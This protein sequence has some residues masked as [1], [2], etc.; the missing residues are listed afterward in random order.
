MTDFFKGM[1]YVFSGVRYVF[2]NGLKRFIFIPIAFNL[3]LFLT[4]LYL[5]YHYV[6][7]FSDYYISKLPSWLGFLNDL[8]L[9][10]FFIVFFLLFICTFTV[11]FNVL[12][13]PFNGLL[14]EKAQLLF[15]RSAIPSISFTEMIVR[16]IKR[17]GQ[18]LA[19]FI[20]R[21]LGL[22]I[23]FF[24]PL[25][26]PIYPFLWILF[27]GWVLST[28]YQDLTMD[29]NLINFKQMQAMMKQKTMLSLGFGFTINLISF[30]PFLNLITVP[31]AV[32][33]GVMLYCEEHKHVRLTKQQLPSL[34]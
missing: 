12:A 20:P 34:P 1:V 6:A 17:Q 8:I 11:L 7:P 29:N 2:T 33:G 5:I 15:Y 22:I 14:A 31:A 9:I 28:Q 24:V 13:A 19:Y 21:F 23:L 30:I 16:S 3:V 10:L 26:Q 18:F 25:I 32:I 27:T 4:S